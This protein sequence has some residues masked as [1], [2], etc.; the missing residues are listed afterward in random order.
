MTLFESRH[1]HDLIGLQGQEDYRPV[2]NRLDSIA[3]LPDGQR[4]FSASLAVFS[5]RWTR[6]VNFIKSIVLEN[7]SSLPRVAIA[8]MNVPP[9]RHIVENIP[10]VAQ[11]AK[12]RKW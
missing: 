5:G 1:E 7:A 4:G 12:P 8:K 3:L 10:G 11:K 9:S 6:P 2:M